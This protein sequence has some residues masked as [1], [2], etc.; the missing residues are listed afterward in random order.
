MY[1]FT[2]YELNTIEKGWKYY[3]KYE[4][5]EKGLK[6]KIRICVYLRKSTEDI[7][8]NS[9]KLQLNE[10]NKFIDKINENYNHTFL[11]YYEN[12]D[13]YKEDNVSG[14]QGRLRPE[15]DR[16][17]SQIENNPGYYGICLVYKM[18]RFSRKLEDT[19]KYL[20]LLKSF[21]C[22]LKA[23]DFDDN[24]DPTSDLLKNML[25]VVAQYHAQNSAL[26]SIKGTLKK[27]EENKTVG[28]LPFGLVS[29]KVKMGNFSLKGSSNIVIDEEKAIIVKIIFEKYASGMSIK[30]IEKLLEEKGYTKDDGSKIRYQQIYYMLRNKR[31]NGTYLYADPTKKRYYKYDNGVSKPEYYEKKNAFPKIIDDDL[32]EKVQLM[33]NGKKNQHQLTIGYSTYLLSGLFYCG[34]CGNKLHGWSRPKYKGKVYYDYVCTIHKRNKCLCSTKRIN[35]LYIE[36]IV[37]DVLILVLNKIINQKQGYLDRLVKLKF[38]NLIKEVENI[39]KQINFRKLKIDKLIDRSI[40]DEKNVSIYNEKIIQLENEINEL[41][42]KYNHLVEIIEDSE[43]KIKNLLNNIKVNKELLNKNLEYTKAILNQIIS[44]VTITN[45]VI[46]IYF[47]NH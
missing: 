41:E 21:K 8:D 18:D 47:Y 46:K 22:V 11:F 40:L 45:E 28:L 10:I 34:E 32:F 35:K 6:K 4:K 9:L 1:D 42:Q 25:G 7:K 24:G 38:L 31:Y 43:M 15:F 36:K 20:S 44:K 33:L 13:I 37:L 23:L 26:T 16:M 5:N 19:L 27:V 2:N 17:L 30:D 39:K 29:E 14:M 12:K 3:N